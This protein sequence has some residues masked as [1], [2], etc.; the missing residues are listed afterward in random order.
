MYKWVGKH[1]KDLRQKRNMSMRQV[2]KKA[3][4]SS[5][6]LSQIET[7]QFSGTPSEDML[8]RISKAL[9]LSEEE[10]NKVL[11]IAALEKTPDRIKQKLESNIQEVSETRSIPIFDSVTAGDGGCIAYDTPIAYI[12]IPVL[13]NGHKIVGFKVQ[14]NSMEPRLKEGDYVIVQKGTDVNDGDVG[15]F[16]YGDNEL[17]VKKYKEKNNRVFLE[18]LNVYEHPPI[19]VH[20]HDYFRVIGKVVKVIQDW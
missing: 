20:E 2:A 10:T 4:M 14:G 19:E 12:D 11:D 1:L 7:N 18:S 17:M 13:H 15:V 16:V 6:Y 5:S 8:L 9:S 3:G